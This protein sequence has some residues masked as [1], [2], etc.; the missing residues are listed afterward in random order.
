MQNLLEIVRLFLLRS[1]RRLQHQVK[2][3][4]FDRLRAI[5]HSRMYFKTTYRNN[6]YPALGFVDWGCTLRRTGR[7]TT[8]RSIIIKNQI[9]SRRPSSQTAFPLFRF[10]SSPSYPSPPPLFLSQYLLTSPSLPPRFTH[11][12][13]PPIY[14]PAFLPHFLSISIC[15]KTRL[16]KPHSVSLIRSKVGSTYEEKDVLRGSIMC[17]Y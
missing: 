4:I 6:Q 10:L 17:R 16:A 14:V 8:A 11:S 9:N 7:V 5:L 12:P 3:N 1:S 13:L 15:S 2:K